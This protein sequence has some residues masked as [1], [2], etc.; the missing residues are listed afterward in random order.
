MKTQNI[1]DLFREY[2][3]R[4]DVRAVLEHYGAENVSERR[5]ADGTTEIVHSCLLDRVEPH[6]SHGDANPSASANVE[7]GLYCCYTYWS[8]TIFQLIQRLEGPKDHHGD[9]HATSGDRVLEVVTPFLAGTSEETE[10]L[11]KKIARAFSEK[12][13]PAAALP[14]YSKRV[15]DDWMCCHPYMYEVRGVDQHT[16]AELMLGYDETENRI[17][18]P[19]FWHG[20]LVGWQK[21]AIPASPRWPGTTPEHP[22]Y[23]NSMGFPK[24]ETLYSYDWA[25][26]Y[27][28]V[29]VVESPMSVAKACSLSLHHHGGIGI[30]ATFG[31]SVNETQIQLL[32]D[33]NRV[34]VWSDDDPAGHAGERKLVEGLY[35][36]TNVLVVKPEQG[37]D[38]ADY[39]G[40][41]EAYE[42]IMAATP[43]AL[44]LKR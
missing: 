15:L 7:K 12:E 36:H 2:Q 37:R 39:N 27:D 1:N 9:H 22:K 42:H 10:S 29:L 32:R 5:G 21:R 16:H 30:V 41:R 26:D 44:W 4:L 25:K 43:A 35:R 17:V 33:F 24:S 6:H 3:N 20:Q 19:H 28:Q 18:F 31:A 13:A 23:K 34:Y 40:G 11:R 38:L 8:G 14:V